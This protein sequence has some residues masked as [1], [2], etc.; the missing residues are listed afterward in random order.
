M[1]PPCICPAATLP[2]IP[3]QYNVSG[4][5]SSYYFNMFRA[6]DTITFLYDMD[7]HQDLNCGNLKPFVIDT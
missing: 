3:R 6:T 4:P 1:P 5:N 7:S 2:N